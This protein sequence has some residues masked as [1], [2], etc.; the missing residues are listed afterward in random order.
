MLL[1]T[2]KI[3]S[4]SIKKTINLSI[5]TTTKKYQKSKLNENCLNLEINALRMD[6]LLVIG[7]WKIEK[8]K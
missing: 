8:M 7:R 3:I 2:T 5:I 1:T 4:V 6:A